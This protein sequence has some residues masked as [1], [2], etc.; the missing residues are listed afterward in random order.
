MIKRGYRGR[1]KLCHNAICKYPILAKELQRILIVL[2]WLS[3]NL[4]D[5]IASV[6]CAVVIIKMSTLWVQQNGHLECSF[7]TLTECR[8]SLHIRYSNVAE[9][10]HDSEGRKP[11]C[12]ICLNEVNTSPGGIPARERKL[13]TIKKEKIWLSIQNVFV[14]QEEW[15]IF[16]RKYIKMQ[17]RSQV[18]R[19]V[20]RCFP[21]DVGS[22][23]SPC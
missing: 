6:H 12:P 10:Q 16:L 21:T 19:V 2:I 14:V 18:S 5:T 13:I 3:H 23:K 17:N 11:T 20:P 9:I 4:T 8:V 15:V 22:R 7:N 1:P